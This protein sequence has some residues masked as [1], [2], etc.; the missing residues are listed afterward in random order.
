MNS[1]CRFKM[2]RESVARC[3]QTRRSISRARLGNIEAPKQRWRKAESRA[4]YRVLVAAMS[5]NHANYGDLLTD[6]VRSRFPWVQDVPRIVGMLLRIH[7][8]N[9]LAQ[10]EP[11]GLQARSSSL[12][13]HHEPACARHRSRFS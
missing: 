9:T 13:T 10:L 3:L 2:T 12:C 7:W 1:P 11:I 6:R 4:R 8:P 5:G